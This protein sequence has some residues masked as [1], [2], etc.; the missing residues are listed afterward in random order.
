MT[1]APHIGVYVGRQMLGSVRLR[2][3]QY[4]ARDAKHKLIGRFPTVKK[5]ADAISS[6]HAESSRNG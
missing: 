3:S 1:T 6:R 4:E 5:A 2:N